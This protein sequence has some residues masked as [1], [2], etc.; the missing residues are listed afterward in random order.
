[1]KLSKF[2]ILKNNF[3]LIVSLLAFF[4]FSFIN[5]KYPGLQY[6]E[7]LFVNAARGGVGND[8]SFIYKE[9]FDI[10]VFLMQYIGALKSYIYFPIFYIFGVN[11][12]TIRIPTIIISL[13]SL[14]IIHKAIKK[15]TD[16]KLANLVVLLLSIN[17][18]FINLTR[19]DVGPNTIE[20]FLKSIAIFL[21][22]NSKG[23]KKYFLTLII[24]LL[25]IFNKFNFIWFVNAFLV[26][27]IFLEIIN[28]DFKKPKIKLLKRIV[29]ST[30][31]WFVSVFFLFRL[32]S[33]NNNESSLIFNLN[34][35]PKF[36]NH[37]ISIVDQTA[38]Y[39]YAINNSQMWLKGPYLLIVFITISLSILKLI[40][41]R[42]LQDN[43][44]KLYVIS[45]IYFILHFVQIL[46]TPKATAPWHWFTIEPFFTFILSISI[47]INFKNKKL[48]LLNF[49]LL[50]FI[51]FY[52]LLQI[53][54]HQ[55][56]YKNARNPIWSEEIYNLMDFASNSNNNF[57]SID[58]GFH[59]QFL[60]TTSNNS[61]KFVDLSFI[62]NSKNVD[63]TTIQNLLK[64][65]SEENN[66]FVLHSDNSTIFKNSRNNFFQIFDKNG[67]KLVLVKTF[68]DNEKPIYEIYKASVTNN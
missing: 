7:V 46:V 6:D 39:E 60:I 41:N 64:L 18:V 34:L 59:N 47:Y 22:L 61:S 68:Y 51:L 3:V 30:L 67:V 29:P 2:P 45:W 53:F 49:I 5:L 15:F 32:N 8:K 66:Y 65:A 11:V 13:F 38:F 50:V 26:V 12:Y 33:L 23:F 36:F 28:F 35:I 16:Q 21:L 31:I 54:Y 43:I 58:W 24:F 19:T 1:M 37:I 52:L 40:K 63:S 9:F 27:T 10:P 4:V 44:V 62:L 48:Y 17:S 55:A 25:G 57:V 14:V 20:F 42:D 56:N